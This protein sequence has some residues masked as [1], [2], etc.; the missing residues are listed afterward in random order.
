MKERMSWL[1]Q[2][3]RGMYIHVAAF[4]TSN[5]TSSTNAPGPKWN[6]M[7]AIRYTAERDDQMFCES[8]DQEDDYYTCTAAEQA[9]IYYGKFAVDIIHG[10]P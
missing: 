3:Y 9:A 4:V 7:M 10:L 1:C 2:G 8:F 5:A 6:Y